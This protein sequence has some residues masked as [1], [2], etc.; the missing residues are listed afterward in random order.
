KPLRWHTLLQAANRALK[1]ETPQDA[2]DKP[3]QEL[4]P[5]EA[6]APINPQESRRLKEPLQ[7]KRRRGASKAISILTPTKETPEQFEKYRDDFIKHAETHLKRL[8]NDCMEQDSANAVKTSEG[9]KEV[10]A[11]VGASRVK[12]R[13][14][15]IRGYAEMEDWVQADKVLASLEEELYS[16]LKAL[17]Q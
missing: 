13:T 5:H 10:A 4:P 16:A 9:L 7:K 11:H 8:K 17:Q 3:P 12:T 1:R 2:P 14:I 15:K 6:I